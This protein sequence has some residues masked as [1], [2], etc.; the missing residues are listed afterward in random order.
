LPFDDYLKGNFKVFINQIPLNPNKL[1]FTG[2]KDS[3][4][5]TW[6]AEVIV[7]TDIP[8]TNLKDTL[9]I[10][11]N[12]SDIGGNKADHGASWLIESDTLRLV[13]ISSDFADQTYNAPNNIDIFIEFNKP[14]RLKSGRSDPVLNLKVGNGTATAVYK[15][16]QINL[17]TKQYFTYTVTSGQN[18]TPTDPWIDVTG[19]NGLAGGDYWKVP[20]YP[21]TWEVVSGAGEEE[22]RISMEQDHYS[23]TTG[24]IDSERKEHRHRYNGSYRKLYRFNQ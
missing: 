12:L 9:V 20:N 1:S 24:T 14:V 10:A 19:L 5:G 8:L 13:R 16:G 2:D 17:N 22:I 18:T 23:S 7:D 15:S 6:K 4:E 3:A 11:A 21:F